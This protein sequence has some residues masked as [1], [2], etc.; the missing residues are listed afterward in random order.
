MTQTPKSRMK[1]RSNTQQ[2]D[3]L[4]ITAS[5]PKKTT[6]ES[7][8]SRLSPF[9]IHSQYMESLS[10]H[11]LTE[12]RSFGFVV[13]DV[14]REEF[15]DTYPKSAITTESGFDQGGKAAGWIGTETVRVA[16]YWYCK[17]REG[18][19]KVKYDV[20]FCKMTWAEK[21]PGSET[22][23]MGYCIP[24]IPVLGKAM[25]IQGKPQL[26]SVVRFQRAAQQMINYSKSRIA[27]T[28][29][30]APIS[31]YMVA[32]GQITK[33]DKKWENLNTNVYPY[34]EYN[35]VDVNGKPA[36]QPQRQ[37]F[38][39]PI[40]S[41]SAFVAQEID[42]MK[43]T[44]GIFDA[45]LGQKSN[46][47]SG[48]AIQ[49][50]QQQT[51]VTVMHF[52]DN[53]ERAFKKGGLI[54]QDAI[55]KYYDSDRMVD[56]LGEDEKPKIARINAMHTDKSGKQQHY[57][58]GG[59]GAGKYRTVVTMGRAFSTKRQESF[60][61]M[62]QLVQSAPNLLPMFG[63]VLFQNSDSAGA[64]I[65]AERFKKMLPPQLQEQ[66]GDPAQQ[67]QQLQGQLQQTQQHLQALNA[68]ATKLEQEKQGKVVETQGRVQIEQFKAQKEYD[69]KALTLQ[70][71]RDIAEINTK[72]QDVIERRKLDASLDQAL[73][74]S[75]HEAGMQ[76]A[77]Q[78]HQKDVAAQQAA[79]QAASQTSDQAHDQSMA[80]QGHQQ[81][82]EQQQ[83]AADNQPAAGDSE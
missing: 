24:I 9:W 54:L 76:A 35:T 21:L 69:L 38:E 62:Q 17:K 50:R 8:T 55:P 4:A 39:P 2:A 67:A 59:D 16:E 78:A 44:T 6:T 70:T 3:P 20:K 63:D 75:A 61:M 51:N 73:H 31:P 81:T 52:M 36:P 74:V 22:E 64:D 27:E 68:Y 56:M 34:I 65:V 77:D 47:T 1:R 45:S 28:L 66:D 46:E 60:D 7:K 5:C 72:A 49:R 32:A 10:R 23:W 18:K 42:D 19:G 37:T 83:A 79:V 40:A 14:P 13:E 25:I 80:D 11:A 29:A 53:L 57:K 12:N 71:Q 26:F 43:A 30:T 58:V 33:G 82:L 48:T 41:L 15:E